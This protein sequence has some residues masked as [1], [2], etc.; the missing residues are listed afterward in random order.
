MFKIISTMNHD[1][2]SSLSSSLRTQSINIQI[3]N[4]P[5]I[6]P[7]TW[8]IISSMVLDSDMPNVQDEPRP[9]LARPVLLGAQGVTD[10]V[11]GSSDWLGSV[12]FILLRQSLSVRHRVIHRFAGPCRRNTPRL[13][14]C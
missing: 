10:R 7:M 8:G 9:C 11:V 3:Q 12:V 14:E 2:L 13:P 4:A 1:V 5:N 6:Q